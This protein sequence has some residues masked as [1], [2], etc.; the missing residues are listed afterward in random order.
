MN[1]ESQHFSDD[2]DDES[3]KTPKGDKSD[4]DSFSSPFDFFQSFPGGSI[5][6]HIVD[7]LRAFGIDDVNA[8]SF[9]DFQKQA[10][11]FLQ[12][13]ME[14]FN[15][16]VR[17]PKGP[18]NW[19]MAL[20]V[21][22][23]HREFSQFSQQIRQQYED[24][25]NDPD[26]PLTE[27]LPSTTDKKPQSEQPISDD[28][29]HRIEQALSVADLW[30]NDACDLAPQSV[31]YETWDRE[32]WIRQTIPAWKE[33]C[34]PVAKNAT[35]AISDALGEQLDRMGLSDA[36][37]SA[38]IPELGQLFG[39]M[40]PQ[41]LVKKMSG[42]IFAM[43]IGQALGMLSQD[44][45]GSTDIGMPLVHT[46]TMA[47]LPSNIRSFAAGLDVPV[48]E[49]IQFLAVREAAYSRL[50]GRVP[51]LR[52]YL[53]KAIY[54]YASQISIDSDA[55]DQAM[56]T[57]EDNLRD[58][59][60]DPTVMEQGLAIDI[61]STQHSP[62][63][64]SSLLKLQT[65]LAV[66]EGWVEEVT[67]DATVGKLPH[68]LQLREMLRR[69][70][71]SGTPAEQ[72]LKTLVG[73]EMRPKRVRDAVILWHTLTEQEGREKRDKLWSHPD[74]MPTAEELE[75]PENFLTNREKQRQADEDVDRELQTLL[76][77]TLGWAEG[78]TP[79]QD[80][81]GDSKTSSED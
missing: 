6:D 71:F 58:A 67:T 17:A 74:V 47:L 63:Q 70:R 53:V 10:P 4:D 34:E 13:I 33:I 62:E 41:E 48:D 24:D 61:F 78:L 66:I 32:K 56:T 25:V 26:N 1:D 18:V 49:V 36:Q 22:L 69:R 8:Q 80:S 76:D 15:S 11:G 60:M 21:A 38:T 59:Q 27:L 57:M 54:D 29:K 65:T 14:S 35:R 42:G 5:P 68:A 72:L 19:D 28:D 9:Q 51:W 20:D 37:A 81:E 44:T 16:F 55:I 3:P 64:K 46:T 77:G 30:L 31:V 12:S 52:S 23:H 45:F 40:D 73:L 79:D 2:E 39:P 7:Q 75:S 50:Y 43:Q